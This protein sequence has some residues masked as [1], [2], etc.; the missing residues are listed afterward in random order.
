MDETTRIENTPNKPIEATVRSAKLELSPPIAPTMNALDQFLD[1][2]ATRLFNFLKII[3][4]MLLLLALLFILINI[5]SKHG[6]VILPFEIS[7]NESLSGIAIADQL[8]AE[9]IRIKQIHNIK[10]NEL[11]LQRNSSLFGTQFTTE[12]SLGN[13]KMVDP[14][15]K[16]MEFS[17]A[18][19]GTIDVGSNS[20]SLGNIII[21]FKNICPYSNPD[22]IIRGSLQRYGSTIV[23]VA[24]LEGNDVQSWTVRQPIDNNNEEQLHEM[25]RNLSFM[26]AH[27][28]PQSNVSAKTWSGLK[29]YTEAI[30]AFHQ[31]KL[32]EN[33][34][35]LS[36][37]GNY[38]LEAISSERGY[39]EPFDLLLYLEATY[40]SIGRQSDATEYCNRT[41][42]LFPKSAD[43]WFNKG[44]VLGYLGDDENAVKA[45]D[46]AIEIDP[47]YAAASNN[48]GT[49][50]YRLKKYD[51][52]I[53]A[54]DKAIEIDPN[55]AAAYDNKGGALEA[56]NRTSEANAV[57]DEA[58]TLGWIRPNPN[59][60]QYV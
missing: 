60:G 7:K 19:I 34:N 45:Y 52:A 3:I 41:T 18:D 28:L 12:Q 35:A 23:I 53:E 5:Y 2:N 37:A 33:L 30:D 58:K 14:K 21:A 6:I 38:S 48:K 55:Y 9:L 15:T 20:L 22:T 43:G 10:Y 16:F 57:F 29:Y 44:F 11:I 49:A 13:Q 42:N 39:K 24:L 27:D 36:L 17:M 25:I 32:S 4:F 47:N 31:Y 56:L 51:D 40:A 26:I 46:K 59:N 54:Y 1:A 8:T 50:L